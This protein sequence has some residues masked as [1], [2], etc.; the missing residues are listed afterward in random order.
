M[1]EAG[2][3]AQLSIDLGLSFASLATKNDCQPISQLCPA[4]SSPCISLAVV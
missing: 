3:L 2:D 4:Q 1:S